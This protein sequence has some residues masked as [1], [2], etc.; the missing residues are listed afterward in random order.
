MIKVEFKED[1]ITYKN[2][3]NDIKL[4]NFVNTKG[5]ITTKILEM[6]KFETIHYYDRCYTNRL[7]DI[8]DESDFMTKKFDAK[9]FFR[10]IIKTEQ[11][12]Y[13]KVNVYKNI[14]NILEFNDGIYENYCIIEHEISDEELFKIK[15]DFNR[16]K[17]DL[18]INIREFINY[19]ENINNNNDLNKNNTKKRKIDLK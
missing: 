15:K 7:T 5:H 19:L 9:Q 10:L 16:E 17:Y 11:N 18:R 1:K 12:D 6:Y 3:E 14:I 13:Y 2:I 8:Y 4:F